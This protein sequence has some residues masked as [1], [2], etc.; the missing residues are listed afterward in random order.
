MKKEQILMRLIKDY[1]A[2]HESF[3]DGMIDNADTYKKA[4]NSLSESMKLL[5]SQIAEE[6]NIEISI[7][8]RI[9]LEKTLSPDTIILKTDNGE[10]REYKKIAYYARNIIYAGYGNGLDLKHYTY[11]NLQKAIS[12]KEIL[13]K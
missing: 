11:D 10:Y 7:K 2:L 12:S 13:L 3:I 1:N 4:S 9:E 5:I 8:D 6:K